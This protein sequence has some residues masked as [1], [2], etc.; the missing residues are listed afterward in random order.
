MERLPEDLGEVVAHGTELAH[1][2]LPCRGGEECLLIGAAAGEDEAPAAVG[3]D[4]EP[5]KRGDGVGVR[6]H[7]ASGILRRARRDD[8]PPAR[9]LGGAELVDRAVGDEPP[10]ADDDDPVAEPLDDV[11]LVGGEQRGHPGSGPLSQH[12]AHDV[13]GHGVQAREGLVED[14][15]LGGAD[16]GGRELDARLVAQTQLLDGG[17]AALGHAEPLGP[18]LDGA[19][20]VGLGDAVE[21]GE[22]PE[23]LA[24]LHLGVETALLGHVADGAAEGGVDGGSVPGAR[25]GV[26][27]QD[28]HDDAH[29]RGLAGSVRADEADDLAV[30]EVEGEVVEGREAPESLGQVVDPQHGSSPA[31]VADGVRDVV[32]LPSQ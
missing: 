31:R 18:L 2:A 30:V 13:D 21:A 22:V 3:A 12:L 8:G 10:R 24:D 15:Q 32:G 29:R 1:R 28:S 16:E 7:G 17:A 27:G 23:L 14:E 20:G 19:L 9:L 6:E 25:A 26:G 5:G 4:L 11:E